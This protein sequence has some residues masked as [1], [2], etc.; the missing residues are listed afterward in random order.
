M[1]K[2]VSERKWRNPRTA[3]MEESRNKWRAIYI[4]GQI[5]HSLGQAAKAIA[6]YQRVKDRFVDARQAINYFARKELKIPEVTTL[7]PKDAVKLKLGY[8][9]I[10]ECAVTVYRIDLLKFGLLR[11]NLDRIADIN[12]AGIRPLH[13]VKVA[14][15]DGKDYADRE[16]ELTLPIKEEGAYLVVCR[17]GDIHGSGML[18]VSPLKLD[19]REQTNGRVRTTV[20]NAVTDKYVSDVEVKVIGTNNHDFVS[21]ETDLRGVFVADEID[22][23]TMVIARSG[24]S[25]YAFFRGE[26]QIGGG[27]D[28][29]QNRPN[30]A[31]PSQKPFAKAQLL[32]GLMDGNKRIQAEQQQQLDELYKGLNPKGKGKKGGFQGGFGGGGIF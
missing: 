13:S 8:R 27:A 3:R 7:K 23:R 10:K 4:A 18:V 19:V 17:G 12:L 29:F 1:V 15:G 31:S 26:Y 9:N 2:R 30:A 5:H 20:K 22:G 14:L 32:E 25:R 28:H 24:K 11:R 6:E 16:K 21:G